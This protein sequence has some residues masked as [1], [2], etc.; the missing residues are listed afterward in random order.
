LSGAELSGDF[1][2]TPQCLPFSQIPHTTPLFSDFLS[3]SPKVKQFY[4]RSARF[5]EWFQDAASTVRYDSDRRSHVA[6]TLERQNRAWGTSVRT[7]A[8]LERFRKGAFA[9]VSGQQ[10]GLFGG[11]LFTIFKA[12]TAVKLAEE[13]SSAGVD[14]VP[15]FWLAG[16]DHDLAE[17]NHAS[18]LSPDYSLQRLQVSTHGRPDS[19]VGG[20]E[21]GSEIEPVLDGAAA[22]LGDAEVISVLRESYR[23]RQTFGGAFAKLMAKLFADWGLILLDGSDP[24]LRQIAE[25][26]FAESI[27]RSAELNAALLARGKALEAEGYHQQVKVTPPSTLLFAIHDGA[28]VAIHRR[29]NLSSRSAEF[30]IG[31]DWL[32]R[33]EILRRIDERPGDFSPNVLL[34]PVM[35]D[36]LLPTLAYAG[37][38]A[39][40]AYFAQVGVVYEGLGLNT[41]PIVPRMSATLVGAKAQS[42]L[43]RYGLG[44]TDIFPG[45]VILQEKIAK[46]VLPVGL[47]NAF[48]KASSGLTEGL[49]E[50]R[51]QLQRLDPT[52]VEAAQTA[53]SKMRHQIERLRGKSARAEL[54]RNEVIGRHVEMLSNL[55]Y[56]GKS[57]QER[58]I[59]GI[60]FLARYGLGLIATLHGALST[61]CLDHQIISPDL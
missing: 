59:A 27:E 9:V 14:C 47:Q 10:V 54:R 20:I 18:V 5:S 6:E 12:L 19:S 43:H 52:L 61:D 55:L 15:V 32:T 41:T 2:V 39:E 21:F 35:Q 34:R 56:P 28:R 57:L 49:D 8:N 60:Y 50:I 4:P 30:S 11:S 38:P 29:T 48:E 1:P 53:A 36:F 24:A 46:R 40:V 16:E 45:S 37:G 26:I 3:A 51:D 31:K 58:E 22:L 25:P 44:L 42:L 33:E 7:T 13:A 17:V 23:P